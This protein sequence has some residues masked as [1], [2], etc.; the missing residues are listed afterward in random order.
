MFSGITERKRT[1]LE[2]RMLKCGLFEKDIE[3]SFVRSQGAGGQK[4]NKTSSCVNLRHTVSGLSVKVQK[5]RQQGLN[6]YYARKQMCELLEDKQLG[7]ESPKAKKLEKIRK[8]KNRRKRRSSS[9]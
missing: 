6:R 8:Q 2:D 1:D 3:E 4:V 5:S 9:S 7:S